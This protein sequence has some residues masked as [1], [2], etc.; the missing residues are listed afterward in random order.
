MAA[1]IVSG[2]GSP[3]DGLSASLL[4]RNKVGGKKVRRWS[5]VDSSTDSIT[6]KV[7]DGERR[8]GRVVNGFS[9]RCR[10]PPAPGAPWREFKRFWTSNEALASSEALD[11]MF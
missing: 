5:S 9:A 4:G 1:W 7:V 3:E 6:G 11:K 2:L 10:S 8:S